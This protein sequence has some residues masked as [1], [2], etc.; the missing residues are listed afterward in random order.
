MIEN[1]RP[2]I[3]AY[4]NHTVTMEVSSATYSGLKSGLETTLIRGGWTRLA[5]GDYISK[6]SPWRAGLP[7]EDYSGKVRI[8]L[9]QWGNGNLTVQ[10]GNAD[11]TDFHNGMYVHQLLTK[12]NQSN[13]WGTK[14]TI[15]VNPYQLVMFLPVGENPALNQLG[16]I[17]STLQVPRFVQERIGLIDAI[18]SI[19]IDT[20]RNGLVHLYGQNNF[21]LHLNSKLHGIVSRSWESQAVYNIS[22]I[23]NFGML[24]YSVAG[25]TRYPEGDPIISPPFCAWGLQSTTV[26]RIMGFLWD[27]M[28][29]NGS[30]VGDSIFTLDNHSWINYSH[31]STLGSL[32]FVTGG[33][34]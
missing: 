30:V 17:V 27:A 5:E 21:Y 24:F 33:V 9:G 1:L 16:I 25:Q 15:I 34:S 23:G 10:A 7:L 28:I 14:Y 29:V 31:L 3:A 22:Y 8:K 20:F 18:I 13:L 2:D 6:Q 32:A 12:D 26:A 19:P 4:T 11:W